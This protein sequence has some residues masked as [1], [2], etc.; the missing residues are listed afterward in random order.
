MH[1]PSD[2]AD[3]ARTPPPLCP[4]ELAP[5]AFHYDAG[6]TAPA[7]IPPGEVPPADGFGPTRYRVGSSR[8]A[9][10]SGGPWL[11]K[12]ASGRRLS[13]LPPAADT[14]PEPGAALDP[15]GPGSPS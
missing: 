8:D 3:S 13:S 1:D 2:R 12:H 14:A 6:G 7:A 4:A 15:P 10:P 5:G 11:E 9:W